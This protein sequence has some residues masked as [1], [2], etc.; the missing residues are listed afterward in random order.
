MTALPVKTPAL[1]DYAPHAELKRVIL[2]EGLK[3][4]V[5]MAVVAI[6]FAVVGLSPSMTWVPEVLL[7]AAAILVPVVILGVTGFRVGGRS[8]RVSAG[9]LAGALAGAIGGL[10][11][12]LSY[13]VFGKPTLNI[14]AGMLAGA[15]AGGVIGATGALVGRRV[16]ESTRRQL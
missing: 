3:G 7:L 1:V 16:G 8:T 2:A 6:V 13:V 12:G 5:A 15:M 9:T 4:G 10:A 11:G 14:V